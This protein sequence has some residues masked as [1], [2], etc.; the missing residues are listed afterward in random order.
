[1]AAVNTNIGASIA[2]NALSKNERSLNTA[3]ERL[4]TGK[5]INGAKDDAAG[6]AIS[7]RMTSQ[8]R[9][10]AAGMKNANDAISMISVAD[11]A[12]VEIGNMLQRMR[13]LALQSSNGTTTSADRDYLDAEYSNLIT[14]IERVAQNT[15]WNGS[16]IL[17]VANNSLKYQVGANGGQT[18]AVDFGAVDQTNGSAFGAFAAGASAVSIAAGTAAS[19][20]TAGTE[21]ITKVDAAIT[22]LNDNRATF[23]AAI[24]QLTYAID[25]LSSVKVNS[26]AARSRIED[27]DYA[28]ETSELARSAII[29]QA[30]LSMLAQ[31]NQVTATVLALLR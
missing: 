26:E 3:V 7:S 19:A 4:S 8:I 29:H 28:K 10:L 9:G 20:I 16:D 21:A 15:Q 2:Q 13:E 11:G 31:A 12:M 14:E 30:G 17:N 18:I 5:R 24:N 22:E 25:N 6:L 27:T 23:G 1:M